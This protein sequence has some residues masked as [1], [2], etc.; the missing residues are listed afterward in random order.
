LVE[1]VIKYFEEIGDV[2]TVKT[3]REAQE[4]ASL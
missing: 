2:E 1:M 3:L 4:R